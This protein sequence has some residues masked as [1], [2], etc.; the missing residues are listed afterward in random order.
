MKALSSP[1]AKSSWVGGIWSKAFKVMTA[2]APFGD[3]QSFWRTA[4]NMLGYHDWSLF[5]SSIFNEEASETLEH[6]DLYHRIDFYSVKGYALSLTFNEF[7]QLSEHLICNARHVAL[8]PICSGS[9]LGLGGGWQIASV[10]HACALSALLDCPPNRPEFIVCGDDA[11]VNNPA[12]RYYEYLPAMLGPS[13]SDAKSG[14]SDLCVQWLKKVYCYDY[15]S[16]RWHRLPLIT[17]PNAQTRRS[18]RRSL[19]FV[20]SWN[21]TLLDERNGPKIMVTRSLRHDLWQYL[22]TLLPM[23]SDPVILPT[24]KDS[25]CLMFLGQRYFL[26]YKSYDPTWMNEEVLGYPAF[27]QWKRTSSKTSRPYHPILGS[28]MGSSDERQSEKISRIGMT[29]IP[30]P[31]M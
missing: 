4:S 21:D 12:E 11:V 23:L 25:D 13:I 22:K 31:A 10:L 16:T 19:A 14:R 2:S 30:D 1:D 15:E 24:D 26:R 9:T 27:V 20:M 7:L 18:R 17:S 5:T 28:Y 29:R 8:G 6:A 3:Y